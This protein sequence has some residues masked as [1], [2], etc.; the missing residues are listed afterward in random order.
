MSDVTITIVDDTNL[1]FPGWFQ[2]TWVLISRKNKIDFIFIV[3]SKWYY[4]IP[5]SIKFLI[6]FYNFSEDPPNNY[7]SDY[8]YTEYGEEYEEYGNYGEYEETYNYEDASEGICSFKST[9]VIFFF[10]I[11]RKIY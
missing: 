9:I 2:S 8:Y 1:I 3:L 6:I 7:G 4:V 5:N 11:G 10:H